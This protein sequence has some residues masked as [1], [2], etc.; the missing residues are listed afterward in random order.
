MAL[1]GGMDEAVRI[2]CG[3]SWD[4][5][6]GGGDAALRCMAQHRGWK[7]AEA[8]LPGI[9]RGVACGMC[10]AR[11]GA[12]ERVRLRARKRT[13]ARGCVHALLRCCRKCVLCVHANG[14]RVPCRPMVPACHAGQ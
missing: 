1:Q 6:E 5:S 14:A 13:G 11:Q 7:E 10:C 9:A 8:T 12:L 4:G 3:A 2:I